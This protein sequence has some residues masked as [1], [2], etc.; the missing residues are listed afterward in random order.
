MTK[1]EP[2]GESREVYLYW[3]GFD[4]PNNIVE[5]QLGLK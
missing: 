2:T 3:E 1:G 5:L 4:S